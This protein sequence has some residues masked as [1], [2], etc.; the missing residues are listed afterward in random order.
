MN[1]NQ[2]LIALMDSPT[3]AALLA[4]AKAE[5]A[6]ANLRRRRELFAE[7][8]RLDAETGPKFGEL[9]EKMRE[10][11]IRHAAAL[12]E[13]QSSTNN[14]NG[15]R[16][17]HG[18]L[19][20]RCQRERSRI[21]RGLESTASP[22]IDAFLTELDAARV[23]LLTAECTDGIRRTNRKKRLTTYIGEFMSHRPSIAER[24][25]AI[26][27]TIRKTK[28]LVYADC[29]AAAAIAE[30][31]ASLPAGDLKAVA[32]GETELG[33]VNLSDAELMDLNNQD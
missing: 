25:A 12:H 15:L 29:D 6:K 13:W 8:G 3:G 10:A 22:L 24:V 1:G 16:R 21:D 23:A 18:D 9:Q 14:V 5:A 17:M 19:D 31:R 4:Q 11:E 28:A 7:R 26:E 20:Q 2:E 32:I 33:P 27:A 30:I